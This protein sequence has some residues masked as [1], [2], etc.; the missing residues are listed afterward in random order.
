MNN[1]SFLKKIDTITTKILILVLFITTI[2]LMVVANFTTD[3]VNQN[4]LNNSEVYLDFNKKIF[5]QNYVHCLQDLKFLTENSIKNNITA[6]YLSKEDKEKLILNLKNKQKLDFCLF[7]DLNKQSIFNIGAAST[8]KQDKNFLRLFSLALAGDTLTCTEELFGEI[9]QLVVVPVF[10][11]DNTAVKEVL[12]VGKLL[13][14]S[15]IFEKIK[16]LTGATIVPYSLKGNKLKILEPKDY[17]YSEFFI[18]GNQLK[19]PFEINTSVVLTDYFNRPIGNV[20]FGISRDKFFDLENKNIMAIGIIAVI[21]LVVSI[22]IAAL[23]ARTFTNPVLEL[24]KAAKSIAG[25]N[26]NHRVKIKGNDEISD[27]SNSFN[28]MASNL[29]TQEQLKD[30][31]VATLTHDLKVPMLAENQTIAY[32]LR[33][34]YGPLTEEQKEVLSLIKSTNYSSLDMISTLLGVYRY[35]SGN[36]KLFKEKFDIVKLLDETVNEIKSLAEEK[37]IQLNINVNQDNI[38]IKADKREIKRVLHNLISNSI[39]NGISRGFVNCNI[40]IIKNNTIYQPDLISE[41]YT[42]LSES[43]DLSNHVLITIEDNG[44]GLTQK[45]MSL[46]FKRFSLSEGRK[47]AGTGLGLYYS[48]QV[49]KQHKGH[50]WAESSEKG[51]SKFKVA[52]PRLI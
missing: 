22:I 48:F 23:F 41:N 20:Y 1:F 34:A 37:K 17:N 43:I 35:D 21:S 42:T 11:K 19:N 29:Q 50:I 33:E 44:I 2:P 18:Q 32:L 30:N 47:P 10:D 26:L 49:A 8:I 31:F 15:N 13:S 16:N 3:I 39:N 46:V 5:K 14:K 7:L 45:D 25:G 9:Y 4:M 12:V 28:E 40:E 24:V 27:L 38:L 51:G 52:I 6:N 36:V